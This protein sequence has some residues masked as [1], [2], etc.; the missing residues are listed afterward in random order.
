MCFVGVSLHWPRA[1][2]FIMCEFCFRV[3]GI[4]VTDS[5]EFRELNS[6]PL[7][8][9]YLLLTTEPSLL[10]HPTPTSHPPWLKPLFLFH[11]PH[12]WVLSLGSWSGLTPVDPPTLRL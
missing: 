11:M 9:Q 5:D 10:F 6:G 3:P 2:C 4:G 12:S 1:G 8:E 7:E